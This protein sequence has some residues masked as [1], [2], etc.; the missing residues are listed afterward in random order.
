MKRFRSRYVR[1]VL[2]PVMAVSVLSA[3]G[4][5]TYQAMAPS[6]VVSEK[7]PSRVRLTMLDGGRMD[8]GDPIVSGSEIIGH[9]VH[10]PNGPEHY[11]LRAATDSVA[12]IEIREINVLATVLMVPLGLVFVVGAVLSGA[13]CNS[14]PQ[15]C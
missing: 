2:V 15:N 6:R 13:Y 1:R 10:G 8:L 4:K 3:C 5:W 7:E 9:P 11:T 14:F 12:A